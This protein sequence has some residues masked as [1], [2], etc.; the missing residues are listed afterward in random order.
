MEI[1]NAIN[2]GITHTIKEIIEM[3]ELEAV[4]IS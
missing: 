1:D 3:T 2:K 4:R